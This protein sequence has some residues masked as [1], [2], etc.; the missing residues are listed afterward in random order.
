MVLKNGSQRTYSWEQILEYLR[1]LKN[2]KDDCA[3]QSDSLTKSIVGLFDKM[4]EDGKTD[5][6][7]DGSFHEFSKKVLEA[8]KKKADE[9]KE[10]LNTVTLINQLENLINSKRA[11]SIN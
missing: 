2:C 9:P 11:K 4:I 3:A 10:S 6:I 5:L 1:F 8:L 7:Q